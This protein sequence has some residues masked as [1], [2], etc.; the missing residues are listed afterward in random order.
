MVSRYSD[1]RDACAVVAGEA[2]K[3][4]LEHENRTDD[5]TI[6]IIH[7]KDLDH[8][9]SADGSSKSG[10]RLEKM[11]SGSEPS[12]ISLIAGSEAFR[13]V[14]SNFSDL[15]TGQ[16]TDRSP[17]IIHPSPTHPNEPAK[18]NG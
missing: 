11:K 17:A 16:Q 3:L 1:P 15:P 14:R 8:F 9:V 2:Y 6:I 4:W 13:S 12:E 18:G 7:I 5:I 10:S